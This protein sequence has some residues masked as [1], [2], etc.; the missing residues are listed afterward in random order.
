M[1]CIVYSPNSNTL[2]S[3]GR[4]QVIKLWNTSI[5]GL[6]K[7]LT[8][9][10]DWVNALAYSPDRKILATGSADNSIKLWPILS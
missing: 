9:H 1:N 3:P 7:V 10:S 5:G 6:I 2:A 4:D 8:G